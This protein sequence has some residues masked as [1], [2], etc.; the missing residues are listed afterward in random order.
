MYEV[1]V[2][3]GGPSGTSAAKI[4][5]KAGL[6]VLVL[7]EHSSI[8]YPVQ[9]A[10]ILSNSAFAECEVSE[11]SVYNKVTGAKVH[12]SFGHELSFD[13]KETKACIVDR[14]RLDYEMALNASD[15]GA[16]F[17]VKTY[18]E[19]I[20]PK[21]RTI[22]VKGV[23][24][25]EELS[26]NMLIAADGPRS[27]IARGLNIPISK[28]IYSGIQ[29][30]I[31]W[32]GDSNLVELHPN[33]SPDFFGWL[34][35]LSSTRARVGL[36][37]LSN[38]PQRFENF[39]KNFS[40]GNVHEVTGTIPIGIRKKTYGDG[41]LIIGDAAGFPKPTSGGGVYTGV[42]SARH[43][44][45]VAIKACENENFSD[46]FLFEYEKLWQQDFG[47]ELELGLTALEIR[48]KF[49]SEEI[50]STIDLLNDPEV[51]KIILEHGDMDRPSEL[52]KQLL[53]HPAVFGKLGV[54]GLKGV[55]RS[56][57]F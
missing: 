14:G 42:R 7:E 38:V 34:I 40:S 17:Q 2:V 23:N 16:E 46:A 37:G 31:P 25:P 49:S 54:L 27:V 28:Y 47:R 26:Y 22:S 19:K 12:G 39:L 18:V 24:G 15:A 52:M 13:A 55:V 43:A 6:S 5:A 32:E 29:A 1:I 9:C 53:K 8:G 11:K 35:P 33:A 41:C 45:F 3:G 4:C 51:L 57:L 30:E 56:F 44:S 48:K 36:C 10:G 20:H 21:K 50:D